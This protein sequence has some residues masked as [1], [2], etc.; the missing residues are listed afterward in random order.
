MGGFLCI[1]VAQVAGGL[2]WT[3]DVQARLGVNTRPGQV[4]F[5]DTHA[6]FIFQRPYR[7]NRKLCAN[8]EV[9]HIALEFARAKQKTQGHRVA[10]HT[11]PATG[12]R[13]DALGH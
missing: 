2:R 6:V 9:F 7:L 10:A 13:S 11:G 12:E 3:V 8:R 4:A 1:V 5:K